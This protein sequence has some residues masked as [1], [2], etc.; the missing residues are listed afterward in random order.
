[1]DAKGL[2]RTRGHFPFSMD[3]TL[4]RISGRGFEEVGFEHRVGT[5]GPQASSWQG[6]FPPVA[7]LRPSTSSAGVCIA[8]CGSSVSMDGLV[9]GLTIS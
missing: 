4:G 5:V 1:M 8:F 6:C 2:G 9:Q 3:G 7:G